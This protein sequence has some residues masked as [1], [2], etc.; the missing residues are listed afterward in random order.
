MDE[1]SVGVLTEQSS[2]TISCR[3]LAE[4]GCTMVTEGAA[5]LSLDFSS[6]ALCMSYSDDCRP[7]VAVSILTRF[8]GMKFVLLVFLDAETSVA[9]IL[10]AGNEGALF[11]KLSSLL[12]SFA[13][14]E[15][16][17]LQ[18]SSKPP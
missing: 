2:T 12:I 1:E 14:P 15:K 3:S 17:N 11:N 13:D 16:I 18:E 8:A 10:L 5:I 9:L 6:L 7:V 4:L